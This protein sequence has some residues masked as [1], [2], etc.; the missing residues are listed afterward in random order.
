[1]MV[2]AR[3]T[4]SSVLC[5]VQ[6]GFAEQSRELCATKIAGLMRVLASS[7]EES[8]LTFLPVTV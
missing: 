3:G 8:M 6:N 5:A 2:E 4:A 7:D 1:M